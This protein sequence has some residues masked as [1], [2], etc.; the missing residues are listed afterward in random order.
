MFRETNPLKHQPIAV[1]GF[2]DYDGSITGHP[3]GFAGNGKPV[4]FADDAAGPD[5]YQPGTK[6]SI[7][8][9]FGDGTTVDIS[10]MHLFKAEYSAGV[11]LAR[12]FAREG[13][14]L[15]NSFISSPVFNF[16]TDYAGPDF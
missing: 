1:Q 5:T 15:V 3:G 11:S 7:G 4:L 16:P 2:W 8:W 12:P 6:M 10:W 14:Q 13:P 9:R